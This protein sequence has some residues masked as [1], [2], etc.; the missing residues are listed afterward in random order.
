MRSPI[1]GPLYF[2]V[3]DLTAGV[4]LINAGTTQHITPVGSSY[5]RLMLPDGMTLA[6]GTTFTK[7]LQFLNPSRTRIAYTPKVFR[8]LA[9][10]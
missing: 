10:P 1:I 2:V 9:T 8:S 7:T 6:P 5:F 4:N 3:P